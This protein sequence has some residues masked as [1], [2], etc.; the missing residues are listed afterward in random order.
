MSPRARR[1]SDEA[2]SSEVWLQVPEHAGLVMSPRAWRSDCRFQSSELWLQ[3]QST[4]V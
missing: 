2:L 1:S 3:A 4:L